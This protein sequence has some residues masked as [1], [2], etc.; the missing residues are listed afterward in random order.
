MILDM[1]KP[2]QNTDALVM[3]VLSVTAKYD[4]Y[5]E[6][7]WRTDGEH[8]PVTFFAN[9]NDLFYWACSD[10]EA[11]TE[12]NIDLLEQTYEDVAM[13]EHGEC[14]AG[15]LF[16]CRSRGMRPQGAYYKSLPRSLWAL[17][18]ACGPERHAEE[19]GNTPKPAI[20]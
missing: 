16:C 4:D 20:E 10:A 14:Y 15:I 8:A 19:P 2:Q 6:I 11:I 9:C 13:Y 5:E 17:F 18:D 7:W 1:S 12:Q 3:R